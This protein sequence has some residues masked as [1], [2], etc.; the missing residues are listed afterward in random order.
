M[1]I[2]PYCLLKSNGPTVT[3]LPIVLTANI[4]NREKNG[5]YIL[6]DHYDVSLYFRT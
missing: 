4:G 6:N 5:I 1:P 3:M 2:I